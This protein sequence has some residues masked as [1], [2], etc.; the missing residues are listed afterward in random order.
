MHPLIYTGNAPVEKAE[1]LFSGD[2]LFIGGVGA[3]FHGNAADM[4]RALHDKLGFIPDAA[5]VF[6]GHEYTVISCP[7]YQ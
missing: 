5:L 6:A 2:T 3:F 7:M 4:D 1:G